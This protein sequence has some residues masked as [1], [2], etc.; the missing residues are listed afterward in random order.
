MDT[1]GTTHMSFNK[2]HTKTEHNQESVNDESSSIPQRPEKVLFHFITLNPNIKKRNYYASTI[3]AFVLGFFLSGV[4][5]LQQNIL[6]SPDY[7]NYDSEQAVQYNSLIT[8]EDLLVKILTTPFYGLMVDKLGRKKSAQ[9]GYLLITTALLLFPISYYWSSL[10]SLGWYFGVRFIYSNGSAIIPIIPLIADYVNDHSLGKAIGINV[11]S[12]TLGFLVSTSIVRALNSYNMFYTCMTFAGIIFFLGNG[13]ALFLKSG[14]S[15]YRSPKP[16]EDVANS[17]NE[18][19]MRHSSE[20]HKRTLIK[21]EFRTKP[22]ILGGYVFAFLNGT[23][24][25][26]TSQLLNLYVQSYGKPNGR[27]LGSMIVFIA[28][29]A[30]TITSL[31]LGPLLDVIKPLYIAIIA[32]AVT[33]AGYSSIWTVSDPS[34]VPMMLIAAAVGAGYSCSQLLT[35]YLGFKNYRKSM[36]GTLFGIANSFVVLGVIVVSVVGGNLFRYFNRN[37]PFYIAGG[38]SFT[39]LCVFTYLYLSK[40][41]PSDIEKAAGG[42]QDDPLLKNWTITDNLGPAGSLTDRKGGSY[43]S[44]S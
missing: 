31:I 19:R 43:Q 40:I 28:N 4:E 38:C 11:L 29:I 27:A 1:L 41:R 6:V 7:Y 3:H 2:H 42:N 39:C 26:I 5:L 32:F 22:W 23:G 44:H 36:R 13:Y 8:L 20:M 37:W 10:H 9:I 34:N 12:I 24:L 33:L 21:H 25:A 35:N 18:N 17:N 30:S 15:Y 16:V 14:N